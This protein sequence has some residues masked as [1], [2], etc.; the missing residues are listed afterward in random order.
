MK[1]KTLK[2]NNGEK[3]PVLIAKDQGSQD[4]HDFSDESPSDSDQEVFNYFILEF[5]S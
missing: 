1:I 5:I 2:F 4:S 3:R